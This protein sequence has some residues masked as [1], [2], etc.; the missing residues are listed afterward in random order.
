MTVPTAAGDAGDAFA[1]TTPGV[2]LP[3]GVSEH[4]VEAGGVR[5]RYLEGGAA[6]GVPVVLLHGWPTWAEVWLPVARTVGERHPWIAVDLPCQNRSS[7][8]PGG[9][10]SLT[11]YRK[12]LVAFVDALPIPR[13]AIVG[14]SMGGTLAVMVALDRPERVTQVAVLDGAGLLPKLPGRTVRMYIPFL[15]PAL[16][17]APGPRSAR[18]LLVNA[19]FHDPA[20]AD[21]AWIQA[22]VDGWRPRDRR[23]GLI[24]SGFALRRRDASVAADLPRLKAATLIVSGREDVQFP[25]RG[26]EAASRTIP[27]GRFAAIE[28]AGHFP[29]V[30]KPEETARL[31]L[32]FLDGH[33]TTASG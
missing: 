8:L 16:L 32:D 29:M 13:F 6:S 2:P 33:E 19:V 4:V 28:G 1:G 15:V 30:E 18:K 25:W 14:D 11:S 31:L 21:A 5:F 9:D 20:F 24:R 10:C 3:P 26:A 17:R 12:A 23:R 27:D 22:V 7:L